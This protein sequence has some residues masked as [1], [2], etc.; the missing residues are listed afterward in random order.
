MYVFEC[1]HAYVNLFPN[2]YML[3]QLVLL[4]MAAVA[5][6][7]GGDGADDPPPPYRSITSGHRSGKKIKLDNLNFV[8]CYFLTFSLTSIV[9][10]SQKP[11]RGGR[12]R[13][14]GGR[15]G[16]RDG[17]RAQVRE[18]NKN[19]DLRKAVTA[20]GPQSIEFEW[21]D[22]KTFNHVGPNRAWFSNYVGELVRSL[23]LHYPSWH[24][25]DEATRQGFMN[26]LG[27]SYFIFLLII[28]L[29]LIL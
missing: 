5:R 15:G 27:V 9:G 11:R 10:S 19:K 12:A 7:H 6:G 21:R 8:T 2:F 1:V 3:I 20:S 14:A 24:N 25:L 26:R 28:S 16:G 18:A 22:Q 23:P 17:G 4:Q 13:Q 29:Y